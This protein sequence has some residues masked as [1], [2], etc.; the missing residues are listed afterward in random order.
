VRAALGEHR[1]GGDDR[2]FMNLALTYLKLK[3]PDDA[4]KLLER[5]LSKFKGKTRDAGQSLLD[6]ARKMAEEF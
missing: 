3:R 2:S 4:I 6:E 5:D 1:D